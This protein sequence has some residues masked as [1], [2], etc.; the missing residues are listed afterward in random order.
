MLGSES[1]TSFLARKLYNIPN[2]KVNPLTLSGG[3]RPIDRIG[4][5]TGDNSPS[6]N[7]PSEVATPKEIIPIAS[8]E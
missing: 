1:A 4:R 2:D 6:T 7:I 3:S 5:F 8:S